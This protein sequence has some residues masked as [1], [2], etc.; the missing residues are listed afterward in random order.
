MLKREE[1]RA[2]SI[3]GHGGDLESDNVEYF[4]VFDEILKGRNVI[5]EATWLPC[6]DKVKSLK[7]Y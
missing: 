1:G 4:V 5:V 3:L 2:L 7:N 6:N